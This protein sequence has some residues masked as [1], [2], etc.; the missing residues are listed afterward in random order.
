MADLL[1]NRGADPN[2]YNIQGWTVFQQQVAKGRFRPH[3][4]Q[5]LVIFVFLCVILL[6]NREIVERMIENGA[7]V[8]LLDEDRWNALHWAAYGGNFT[9]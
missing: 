8:N 9:L 7:D 6:G 4:H 1:L 2:A 3:F 5:I